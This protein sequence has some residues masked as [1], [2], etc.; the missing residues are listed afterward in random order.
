[1]VRHRSVRKLVVHEVINRIVFLPSRSFSDLDAFLTKSV[2]VVHETVYTI[3]ANFQRSVNLQFCLQLVLRKKDPE[4]DEFIYVE[5]Y[6]LT[7]YI[8]IC[9][10]RPIRRIILEC[11]SNITQLYDN[12]VQTGSGFTLHK[13]LQLE[14][15]II[16]VNNSAPCM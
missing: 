14:L 1:M 5:P 10:T 15:K 8:L 7:K 6:F 16:K 2:G 9:T 12:Y 3:I 11:F 13:I 4:T